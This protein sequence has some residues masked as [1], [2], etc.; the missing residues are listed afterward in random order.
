MS[1][2]NGNSSGNQNPNGSTGWENM[3]DA[4]K[5]HY[6][7]EFGD[8]EHQQEENNR[9]LLNRLDTLIDEGKISQEKADEL[10]NL[11]I[12]EADKKIEGNRESYQKMDEWFQKRADGS[13]AEDTFEGET[14]I[15]RATGKER[16]SSEFDVY[17]RQK[18]ET[19]QEYGER[20]KR[21]HEINAQF[22]TQGRQE[23][24]ERVRQEAEDRARLE[25]EERARQEAEERARQEAEERAR[26][27]AEAEAANNGD[28]EPNQAEDGNNTD[29]D[30][31]GEEQP[32]GEVEDD[33]ESNEDDA[34][35]E[36]R[37]V[38]EEARK[39]KEERLD[40]INK[41]LEKMRPDLAE[42]YA[43]N[44]RLFVGA[45]NR[46]DFI[47]AK[48][49]YQNL[50]DE[51]L[52]IKS[53]LTFEDGKK[54][55]KEKTAKRFHELEAEI[56]AK[57]K[58]FSKIEEGQA[59]KSKEEIDKE[60]D[61]L[62]LQA[63]EQLAKEYK[64]MNA[65]LKA[66]VSA[67]MTEELLKNQNSLED[68]T[69]D[70]LDN[71]SLCRKIVH[72]VL[73]NKLFKGALITA[74]VAGL[75]ITGFGLGA[76]LAAGSVAVTAGYSVGG[77]LA[78]AGRGAI[79]GG[80]MSR[81]DSKNSAV[82]GFAKEEEVKS[83][84]ESVQNSEDHG[85]KDLAGWLMDQY[86]AANEADAS[87]NR[88]RTAISA[89]LGAAIG[90]IMSGVQI[91]NIGTKEV[92][93]EVQIGTEPVEYKP[94]LIDN[95]DIPKGHGAYDTFTQM[96]GDPNKIQQAIDIMHS[97][98]SK[99]GLVPGSN[100]E[101]AGINGQIGD[102]AHTYPGKIDTWPDVAQ[103]YI[104]EVAEEWA[105]NG[106]IPSHTTGGAPI[107][108]TVTKTVET[109]V[110]DAFLNLLTQAT[111][112]VGTGV[113]GGAIGGAE[114]AP[115]EPAQTPETNDG[116]D[117]I[118]ETPVSSTAPENSETETDTEMA[119]TGT[120]AEAEVDAM[121]RIAEILQRRGINVE[122]AG[123]NGEANPADDIDSMRR[124]EEIL[125]A[126]GIDPS[127]D[128]AEPEPVV[129]PAT[130]APSEESGSPQEPQPAEGQSSEAP[131]APESDQQASDLTETLR[132]TFGDRLGEEGISIMTSEAGLDE[133]ISRRIGLW[134][135]TLDEDT[136]REI[137]QFEASSGNT[138]QGS[139]LRT[140]LQIPG[141]VQA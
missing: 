103:S 15:N 77:V 46:A 92:S 71:G 17:H 138:N 91:N 107:Y 48:E 116:D 6:F 22:E 135:N 56:E 37:R 113:I 102:F 5:E 97:I 34:N 54:E 64:E 40:E 42:L 127:R 26:Q 85:A 24:E 131:V 120:E 93:E 7:S 73:N 10:L 70:K 32:E 123:D 130:N 18:G 129:E 76:G 3:D 96:G 125:R 13:R 57:M 101:T 78:G 86:T 94:D 16:S 23:D 29:Q 38:E 134:W 109:V 124:I 50:L 95:V 80:L 68:E 59:P 108:D 74:G 137:S 99:Y 115:S 19:P 11:Q 88:K 12:K 31:D 20:L 132:Q 1:V 49:E 33:H 52:K 75:A 66:E 44:R 36:A 139:A 25:A 9:L 35:S 133:N 27:E 60:R 117:T 112:A 105:K 63:N 128:N 81:Q 53:E 90:G 30:H 55:I 69:I 110:P 140:W 84:L 28:S 136:K 62:T 111:T 89:G 65:A 43:R 118:E 39:E 126:R 4:A 114:R 72:N 87:S 41:S 2:E 21:M 58:E 98:D 67:V 8:I 51:S 79:M 121:R 100:G 14:N 119:E 45:K 122:D 104:K 47:K 106:L 82:R 61:R 141:Q 83:Q